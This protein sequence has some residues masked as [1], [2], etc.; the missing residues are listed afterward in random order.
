MKKNSQLLKSRKFISAISLVIS[1]LLW[2]VLWELLSYLLD[3]EFIFPGAVKTLKTWVKLCVTGD[4]WKTVLLSMVR[5]F[6]GLLLGVIFGI[7]S[8]LIYHFLPPTRS[9][10]GIGM[11]VIKSTPVASIIMV[12]WVIMKNGSQRLPVMIA[13]LMVMPIIWQNLCDGFNSIDGELSEVCDVFGF[14]FKKRFKLLI[15]PPLLKYFIPALLTSIGLAWKSGIAAEIISYTKN[16]IGKNI[17]DAKNFFEGDV[18]L[19]W[20]LSVVLLSLCF[21]HFVKALL[22]RWKKWD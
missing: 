22:E 1:V 13:L 15:L 12:L 8:A 9:F 4:F 7:A 21:E 10:I 16:S 5:I 19:A 18:M 11:T 6:F 17:L 20:T 2:L 3:L 14:S